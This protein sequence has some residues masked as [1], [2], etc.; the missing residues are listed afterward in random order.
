MTEHMH[1][2]YV[3]CRD[4]PAEPNVQDHFVTFTLHNWSIEHSLQCRM[5][6]LMQRGC[7]FERAIVKVSDGGPYED[8]L[9]RWRITGI[10]S[11]GLPSL[12]HA[13]LRIRQ[14]RGRDK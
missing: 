3:A 10:D 11:E 14:K 13:E 4:C 9:G 5:D 2:W 8:Q 6:G 12:E 7:S 1:Q